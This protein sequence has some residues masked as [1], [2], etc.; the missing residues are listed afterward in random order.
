[1]QNKKRQKN[2]LRIVKARRKRYVKSLYSCLLIVYII[3]IFDQDDGSDTFNI[4][5]E[6]VVR[7]L[8]AKGQPIRLF[9]ESDKDRK[10]RLRALEL[11]EERT[12]VSDLFNFIISETFHFFLF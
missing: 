8:R 3:I 1:M 9:G 6:E 4:S 5:P 11:I 12:E 10:T 2:L 7:R